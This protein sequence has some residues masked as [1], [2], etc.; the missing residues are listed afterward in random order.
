MKLRC[1]A[2]HK[3]VWSEKDKQHFRLAPYAKSGF[4]AI[5][6]VEKKKQLCQDALACAEILCPITVFWYVWLWL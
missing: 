6:S 3:K 2:R 1:K 5:R 4:S